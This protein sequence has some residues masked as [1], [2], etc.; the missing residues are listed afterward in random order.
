MCCHSTIF[1][2][3]LMIPKENDLIGTVKSNVLHENKMI[4]DLWFY[5][6]ITNFNGMYF[7]LTN[8]NLFSNIF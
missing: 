7:M 1:H 5:F 2:Y 3:S 6:N 8:T 4:H